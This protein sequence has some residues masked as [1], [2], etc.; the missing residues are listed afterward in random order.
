MRYALVWN[1]TDATVIGR[2]YIYG[3]DLYRAL[4]A[5]TN[6]PPT[7]ATD[8]NYELVP[9]TP[10]FPAPTAIKPTKW[11]HPEADWAINSIVTSLQQ[12]VADNFSVA[13]YSSMSHDDIGVVGLGAAWTP[14][15]N[16]TRVNFPG[17]GIVHHLVDGTIKFIYPGI[18][19]V[20]I[21]ISMEH[22]ESQQGRQTF[23]R[24]L[25]VDNATTE[26][27]APIG[28]ARNQP[29]T[30]FAAYPMFEITGTEIN[31]SYR[32]EL[33][34]GDTIAIAAAQIDY[35]ANMVSEWRTALPR[36]WG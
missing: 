14:I 2:Y 7:G 20:G 8:A 35:E 19:R 34:N 3:D 31:K 25:N 27:F 16:Y 23:V 12:W 10:Q 5:T 15:Q 36:T 26:S 11:M 1:D 21:F 29:S 22:D 6:V 18:Y 28:I 30:T 13:H 33:G 32:L 9:E 17:K 24:I 4:A